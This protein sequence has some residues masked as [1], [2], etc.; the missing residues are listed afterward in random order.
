MTTS[1]AAPSFKPG[2]LPAVTVPPFWNAGGSLPSVSIVVS[3]RM[4]SSSATQIGSPFFCGMCTQTI[5]F[6]NRPAFV[7]AAALACDCTENS[8]C[9]AR[10]IFEF[11]AVNSASA[12]MWQSLN[13]HHRPSLITPS[14]S[15]VS[16]SF[17]PLRPV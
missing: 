15:V 3:G 2:A 9:C 4:G 7:A 13:E 10:V 16:P 14:T 5:S 8:S 17:T 6:L 12:P 11:S 1:A